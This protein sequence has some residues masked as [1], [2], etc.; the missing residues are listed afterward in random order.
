MNL[1]TQLAFSSV[2]HVSL[3][4]RKKHRVNWFLPHPAVPN[5]FCLTDTL[6]GPLPSP[7][8][9]LL[10]HQTPRS[11]GPPSPLAP[12]SE[13]SLEYWIIVS[14]MSLPRCGDHLK[15]IPTMTPAIDLPFPVAEYRARLAR[16]EREMESRGIDV[17]MS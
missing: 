16:V 1:P 14:I 15:R 6:S 2:A 10:A 11:R 13:S 8:I 17:L 12:A 5:L 3:Q 9:A 7:D 4:S